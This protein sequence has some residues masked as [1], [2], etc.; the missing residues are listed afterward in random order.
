MVIQT[1][2]SIIQAA[3]TIGVLIVTLLYVVFTKKILDQ[4]YS[5]FVVIT[6]LKRSAKKISA[7]IENHGTTIALNV[8]IRVFENSRQQPAVL[9]GP[10]MI[11]PGEK[12]QFTGESGP[13]DNGGD[14]RIEICYR[15]QTRKK[16]TEIWRIEKERIIYL[17]NK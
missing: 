15:S 14:I 7:N 10:D 4:N 1:F 5:T 9:K 6:G 12:V 8:A 16:R 13:V 3:M 2:A 17:G 11:I